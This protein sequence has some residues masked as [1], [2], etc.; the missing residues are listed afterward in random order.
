MAGAAPTARPEIDL[1]TLVRYDP[2]GR[3]VVE[4]LRVHP[5]VLATACF[6]LIL[7]TSIALPLAL[8]PERIT[9]GDLVAQITGGLTAGTVLSW[10]VFVPVIWATWAWQPAATSRL[11]LRLHERSDDDGGE[12]IERAARWYGS[13]LASAP[14]TSA[15]A[16]RSRHLP[17]GC[18]ELVRFLQPDLHFINAGP[19]LHAGRYPV[20]IPFVVLASIT[21]YM[22][23]LVVVRQGII[24]FAIDRLFRDHEIEVA[25]VH[26]DERGGLGFLGDFAL[27]IAPLIAAA[28]LTFSVPITSLSRGESYG[29]DSADVPAPPAPV[30]GRLLRLLSGAALERAQADAAVEV[31]SLRPARGILR[32]HATPGRDEM[33]R[34]IIDPD[35]VA[36][37][38]AAKRASDVSKDLPAWP[39]HVGNVRQLGVAILTPL[40][41]VAVRIVEALV[42]L[43]T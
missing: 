11:L 19:W 32:S 12:F 39:I 25:F 17:S 5:L 36:K 41:P 8:G 13:A 34:G 24:T 9:L 14:G 28:G 10:F 20:R 6:V 15:D 30:R 42:A 29:A 4:R 26:P 43:A 7:A 22:L 1:A 37:L 38:E 3:L 23:V 18:F 16:R 31:R 33:R 35:S 27:G 40:L 21:Y 2:P